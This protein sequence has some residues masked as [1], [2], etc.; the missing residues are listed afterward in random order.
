MKKALSIVTVLIAV[1]Y[2]GYMAMNR[3][4]ISQA[5][6]EHTFLVNENQ[7]AQRLVEENKSIP[8]LREQV[9]GVDVLRKENAELPGLRNEARQLRRKVEELD[10]LKSEN[11]R[12]LATPKQTGNAK[13]GA[14]MPE[15]F[16]S[17]A[18]LVDAGMSTPEATVQTFF[19][20]LTH[21]NAER[22]MQC[23]L[24]LHPG[25]SPSAAE[26][27]EFRRAMRDQRFPGFAIAEKKVMNDNEVELGV[28][29]TAGGVVQK[30]V[31][32]RSETGEWKLEQRF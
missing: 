21:E 28:Q 18:A 2:I 29:S 23:F 9:A 12:L 26:Q 6:E 19:W 7:E 22:G 20:A 4:A 14:P 5:R 32:K 17:R 24:L 30:M 3:H 8:Q 15:G 1:A 27:E 25:S 31:L 13:A 11:Q 16:I 10:K